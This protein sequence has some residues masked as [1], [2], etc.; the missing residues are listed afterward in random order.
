MLDVIT[1]NFKGFALYSPVINGKY[2]RMG[3]IT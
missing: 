2:I 1:K 3:L